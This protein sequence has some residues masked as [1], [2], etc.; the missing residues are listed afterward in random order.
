MLQRVATLEKSLVE[1]EARVAALDDPTRKA[2][3]AV[4]HRFVMPTKEVT[5][6]TL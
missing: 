1:L 4:S 6:E 3:V 5:G 2:T